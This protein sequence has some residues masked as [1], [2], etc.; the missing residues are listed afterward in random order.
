V[1]EADDRMKEHGDS[2]VEKEE[3]EMEDDGQ[4]P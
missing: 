2:D 3:M 4:Q 1:W